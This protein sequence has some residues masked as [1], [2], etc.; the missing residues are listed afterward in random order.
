MRDARTGFGNAHES[1][2]A[3]RVGED[4]GVATR[5]VLSAWRVARA[6]RARPGG[7]DHADRPIPERNHR[8]GVC[9]TPHSVRLATPNCW[10]GCAEGAEGRTVEPEGGAPVLAVGEEGLAEAAHPA[11]A[12]HRVGELGVNAAAL[13]GCR[14]VGSEPVGR[15][16][17]RRAV[18]DPCRKMVAVVVRV[19]I[20]RRSAAQ[21]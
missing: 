10:H 15:P 3:E 5:Q 20:R 18:L 7:R 11:V 4:G 8:R 6:V 16:F 2:L 9:E 14:R 13:R 21:M 1:M 12:V 17:E 19:A